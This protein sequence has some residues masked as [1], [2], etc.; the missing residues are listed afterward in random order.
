[1]TVYGGLRLTTL[2]VKNAQPKEKGYTLIDG[3]GLQLTVKID[4]KKIWKIRYTL[5]GKPIFL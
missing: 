5:E 3:G 1:M 2:E 4:G